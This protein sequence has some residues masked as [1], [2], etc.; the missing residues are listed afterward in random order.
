MQILLT[1]ALGILYYFHEQEFDQGMG[2]SVRVQKY[3]SQ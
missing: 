1:S 2:Y 3:V